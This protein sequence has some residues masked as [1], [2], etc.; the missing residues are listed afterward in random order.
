MKESWLLGPNDLLIEEDLEVTG[1]KR[2]VPTE[3]PF[4][5]T[6]HGLADYGLY[7]DAHLYEESFPGT[8]S[9]SFTYILPVVASTLQQQV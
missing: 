6:E 9:C 7:A 2:T 8:Q 5:S 1:E 4:V 3:T